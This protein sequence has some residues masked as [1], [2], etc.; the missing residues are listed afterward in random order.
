MGRKKGP[1]L[2]ELIKPLGDESVSLP[3]HLKQ[4]RCVDDDE[5]LTHNVLTPGRSVRMSIGTVGVF[6]AVAIA[7]IVISYTLGFNRG[8]AIAREDYGIRLFEEIDSPSLAQR[9]DKTAI[10]QTSPLQP[11]VAKAPTWGSINSDPR[12]AGMHY[13]MLS[14]TTKVGAERLVSFCREKGLETYAISG[15]NTRLHRVIALPG[16]ASRNEQGVEDLRL[17]IQGTGR[18]WAEGDGR[19]DDLKDAYLSLYQGG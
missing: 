9:V 18:A 11:S 1:A 4:S 3:T 15:D 14:Q 10:S 16:F 2:Y 13:F 12:R 6:A 5:N 8:E 17:Q 7:L 19:G